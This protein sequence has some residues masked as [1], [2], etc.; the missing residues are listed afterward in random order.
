MPEQR[1]D[2][3]NPSVENS[4]K[5]TD[6]ASQAEQSS[7]KKRRVKKKRSLIGRLIVWLLSTS[8]MLIILL[9]LLLYFFIDTQAGLK[10]L[11]HLANRYAGDYVSIE[12][13]EGRLG[14]RFTL[15]NMVLT[16]PNYE[17]LEIPSVSLKWDYWQLLHKEVMVDSLEVTGANLDFTP[18]ELQEEE[19][20]E[21]ENREPFSLKSLNIPINAKVNRLDLA[22]STLKIHD[23]YLSVNDFQI[24]DARLLDNEVTLKNS[25]GDLHIL[26]GEEIDV[27]FVVALNGDVDAK[28]EA[29]KLNLAVYAQDAY[30]RDNELNIAINTALN[31]QLEKFTLDLDGRI[32]WSNMLNDPILL[33]VQNEVSSLNEVKSYLHIKNLANQ[34]MLNS[35]WA[36]DKPLDFDLA[37]KMN[38]PYLSQFHPDIRGS[39]MG[40]VVLK[41]DLMKPLLTADMA[42]TGVSAFGLQLE[43]LTLKGNHENYDA[44]AALEMHRFKFNEFYLAALSM[45]LE[46]TLTE[47]FD[48]DLIIKDLVKAE[49]AQEVL[50]AERKAADSLTVVDTTTKEGDEDVQVTYA[51]N[52]PLNLAPQG[53]IEVLLKKVEYRVKGEAESH[54]FKFDLESPFGQIHSEGMAA[55]ND[56][57]KDPSFSLYLANSTVKSP[58][59]GN[60]SLNKPAYFHLNALRQELKLTPACYQ[61]GYV[62]LCAEGARSHDGVNTA[63]VTLNNLPSSL[64]K[65]YLPDDIS[66]NTKANAT[67]AGQFSTTEDF[68]GVVNVSLSKGDIRYRLQG[69]EVLIPLDKTLLQV[70]AKPT[71][72]TSSLDVDWGK[73]LRVDGKGSLD[74]LFAENLVDVDLKAN[75]PSFDW[76]SP[77]MPVLQDLGGEVGFS[78]KVHGTIA[79]PKLAANLS[80]KNGKL[81]VA[82]LN[83]RLKD[84]NLNVDL[85]EGTP[86]FFIKGSVG[87]NE[88]A[89]KVNGHYNIANFSTQITAEGENLLLADSENIKVKLSPKLTFIGLGKSGDNKYELKGTVR[90]PELKYIHSSM[91]TGGSVV[92]VSDDT[93]IVGGGYDK[94]R[95]KSFMDSF[96]MDVNIILGKQILVGAEGLKASLDGGLKIS[97]DYMQPI[98]GLGVINVG[99]GEFDI[100]GQVLTLDRGKIQFS[101]TSITNPALDIQASRKFVNEIE[102]RE[103]QVGVKVLGSVESPKIQLYSSPALT[104]IEIASY[105]FLGRSPNLESPTENL[106]LLNMVRK[107][108]MGE[109][110]SSSESSLASQLGLTDFGFVE[111]P[112]GSTGIGLGKRFAN[113]FYVGLGVGIEESEGTFAILRYRFLKYFNINT[114]FTSEG[115]SVNVNYLR[116]F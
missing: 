23:F 38:A 26:V 42:I 94:V 86:E 43:S 45:N 29:F 62:V 61:Q 98:R 48:F 1:E 72:V 41:G 55:L 12:S 113:S 46:G 89:L 87:T 34:I 95:E 99:Q 77:L 59:V 6:D 49:T 44:V 19:K 11:T 65:E 16:L 51:E 111:T 18:I 102:G 82:S 92:T 13:A 14:K 76:I 7:L 47:E 85:K 25:M 101:G 21:E 28:E 83:S 114:A 81:Y 90:V 33:K 66:V 78:S 115:E 15:T 3:N 69:R 22:N 84:I 106:M 73:Y 27:P 75:I 79:D 88:G 105:L 56:L 96:K 57:G 93:I 50:N 60:F 54:D 10:T 74:D 31:G 4:P 103:M 8:L 37:L 91:G 71:G 53:K 32:D 35:D 17:P 104:D 116:D 40:D 97:K 2:I 36:L 68:L 9:V 108:A 70:L 63:V 58:F 67:I 100:Y 30:V 24:E 112:N 80:I 52:V 64:L 109:P 110:I 107:I 5:T 20:V 39:L